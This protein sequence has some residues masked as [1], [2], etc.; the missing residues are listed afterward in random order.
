MFIKKISSICAINSVFFLLGL[1]IFSLSAMEPEQ[2]KIVVVGEFGAGDTVVTGRASIITKHKQLNRICNGDILIASTIHH[3]W[4][5]GQNIPAGI[6]TEKGGSNSHAVLLA[7]KL[8]IPVIVGAAGA[9]KK[10]DNG[11]FIALDYSKKAV[12]TVGKN[13]HQQVE[14]FI[15]VASNKHHHEHHA[16]DTFLKQLQSDELLIKTYV[17][18]TVAYDVGLAKKAGRW[19][20]WCVN[21][22]SY[23]AFDS[24]PFEFFSDHAAIED[25]FKR[26]EEG[27]AYIHEAKELYK[28]NKLGDAT[29]IDDS[30]LAEFLYK[31]AVEKIDIPEHERNV[32]REKPIKMDEYVKKGIVKKDEYMSHTLWNFAIKYYVEQE[33]NNK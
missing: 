16:I 10:I 28:K 17:T 3:S 26:L 4:D 7:Q 20:A 22:I 29:K 24:I 18:E 5:L 13:D 25:V 21:G 14:D 23:Y 33:I 9:T 19:L 15:G 1:S 32:L 12:Y 6:I 2:K 27:A 30:V 8:G 31:Y 11:S